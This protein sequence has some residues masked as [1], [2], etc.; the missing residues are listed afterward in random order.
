MQLA[1]HFVDKSYQV[2]IINGDLLDSMPPTLEEVQLAQYFITEISK[3]SKVLLLD[4]NHEAIN[5]KKRLSLYDFV[6]PHNCE[7]IKDKIISLD[8]NTYRLTSWSVLKRLTTGSADV[9]IT[10]VRANMPP[11]IKA[12]RD[13]QFIKNY[14]LCV[15]GDIHHKYKVASNA[16]YTS[17]PYQVA[18]TSS[19][20]TGSYIVINDD[21]SWEY[22]DLQLPQKI[23]L[24]GEADAFMDFEPNPTDLYKVVVNGTLEELNKLPKFN[25]VFYTKVIDVT[26]AEVEDIPDSTD[27]IQTLVSKVCESGKFKGKETYVKTLLEGV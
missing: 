24:V 7:Y 6:L 23:K 25:N 14:K 11:H 9:L 16:F 22:V 5:V 10:H 18:F 13:M 4:G 3:V 21:L 27:L 26:N 17:S 2:V 12:E 1:A 15:F 20:P 8:G 19:K